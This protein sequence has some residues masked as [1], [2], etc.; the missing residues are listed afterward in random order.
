MILIPSAQKTSTGAPAGLLLSAVGGA[1]GIV[2][3][4]A[5]EA[6]RL[7]LGAP[8]LAVRLVSRLVE[9]AARLLLCIVRLHIQK[10][11]TSNKGLGSQFYVS[12]GSASSPALSKTPGASTFTFCVCIFEKQKIQDLKKLHVSETSASSPAL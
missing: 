9:E 10:A 8:R 1:L 3:G 11:K 2:G 7:V 6:A 5:E 4:A 12:E